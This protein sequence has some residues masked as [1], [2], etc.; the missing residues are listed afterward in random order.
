ML[1]RTA[2]R[3]QS[4]AAGVMVALA[5]THQRV[6]ASSQQPA[7]FYTDPLFDAAHDAEFVWHAGEQCW[8]VTYLQN[9]YNSPLS[10]PDDCNGCFYLY[11]DLGLASTPDNGSTWI[12]RG[13][14]QNLGQPSAWG[15]LSAGMRQNGSAHGGATWWRPAVVYNPDD[16]RYHGFFAYLLQSRGESGPTTQQEYHVTHYTSADLIDWTFAGFLPSGAS[17][18]DTVVFRIKDGRWLLVSAGAH[19]PTL[20]SRDLFTWE[21]CND[22]ALS[23][24]TD[25]GPHVTRW[26]QTMWMNWEPRCDDTNTTRYSCEKNL[27]KSED[28]GLHWKEQPESLFFG[29]RLSQRYLDSGQAHQGPLLPQGDSALVL[30]FTESWFDLRSDMA[31]VSKQRSV[32]QIAPVVQLA[33]GSLRADRSMAVATPVNMLRVPFSGRS[34]C[35]CV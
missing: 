28:G 5:A 33:N 23:F 26:K 31:L 7:P 17:R 14:M 32:L 6:V 21:Q 25:E 24:A 4:L 13:V 15:N 10:D 35:L 8:W 19:P 1:A 34:L 20:Q 30:Y 11:T 3:L 27:L 12:Y 9:R 16:K 18:Y 22:T 2:G 29:S